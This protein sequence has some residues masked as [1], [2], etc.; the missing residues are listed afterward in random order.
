MMGLNALR[1]TVSNGFGAIMGQD[2]LIYK[3]LILVGEF[4]MMTK[5]RTGRKDNAGTMIGGKL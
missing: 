3:S 5:E 2:Y 1:R 4:G